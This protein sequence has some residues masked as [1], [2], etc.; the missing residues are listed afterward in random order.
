[1]VAAEAGTSVDT[2]YSAFGSK[3]G[4]LMAA[5]DLAIA[6]DDDP[7][8]MVDRPELADFAKGTRHQRLRTGVRYTLGVYERSIPILKALQEAAAS[9][10]AARARLR[11][12][13]DDRRK[14]MVVGMAYILDG[15]CPEPL[16]DAIWALVSPDVFILLTEGRGWSAAEAES[17]L[18][19][20]TG[21]AIDN[22]SA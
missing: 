15:P 7:T 12:Y 13:D 2:I 19:S 4:L 6:G 20:M 9:D 21:A 14:V 1:M 3:S 11:K 5:I 16:L 8:S 17:W 18:V 10:G 22:Y